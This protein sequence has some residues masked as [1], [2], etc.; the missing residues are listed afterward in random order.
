MTQPSWVPGSFVVFEG[1][2][3]AGKSTQLAALAEAVPGAVVTHQPSGGNDVGKIVY[4]ITENGTITSPL[5]RQLLHLAAD[6]EHYE[7]EILPALESRA[8]LMDRCWWSTIAYGWYGSSLRARFSLEDFMSSS[9]TRHG[10][11]A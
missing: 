3:G 9:G 8:V 4:S 2:D 5:A 7:T 11:V 1:L 10:P 6:S